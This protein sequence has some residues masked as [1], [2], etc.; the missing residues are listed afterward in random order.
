MHADP[1]SIIL[2]SVGFTLIK[3]K[4]KQVN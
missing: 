3:L 2:I 1:K 4:R